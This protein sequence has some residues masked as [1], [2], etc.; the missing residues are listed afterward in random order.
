MVFQSKGLRILGLAQIVIGILMFV[1]GIASIAAVHHW[2][3]YVA[4][5]IWVGIWVSFF[6]C[7]DDVV[8]NNL[9]TEYCSSE[10]DKNHEK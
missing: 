6:I 10:N 9:N 8:E 2:S 4:C 7:I 5:G 3:S 1:F